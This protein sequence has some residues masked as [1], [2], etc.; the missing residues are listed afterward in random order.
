MDRSSQ[1]V[2]NMT[3]LMLGIAVAQFLPLLVSPILTRLFSPEEFGAF[4][5]FCSMVAFLAVLVSGRYELALVLPR[6][7]NGALSLLLL[8]C[9]LAV[10]NSLGVC[11]L[12]Y[13]FNDEISKFSGLEDVRWL[14]VLPIAMLI[15]GVSQC[16]IQWYTRLGLFSKI[17]YNK[18]VVSFSSAVLGILLG[19]LGLDGG[20]IVAHVSGVFVGVLILVKFSFGSMKRL[21]LVAIK[22]ALF[23]GKKYIKFPLWNLPNGLLDHVRLLGSSVLIIRFFGD[24]ALGQYAIAYKVL[25]APIY[26][27]GGSVASVFLERMANSSRSDIL[28][29]VSWY[30]VRS[31]FLGLPFYAIFYLFSEKLFALTFGE[32]W[33][34]AGMVAKF[35]S[36]WFFMS[37]LTSPLSVVFLVLKKQEVQFVLSCIYTLIPLI[38][39][40]KFSELGFEN[41]LRYLSLT[42]SIF[43]V[44]YLFCVYLIVRARDD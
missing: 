9:L 5:I 18:V 42:M 37:L 11:F 36:P 38:V 33:S 39:I 4:S 20:L 41:T 1:L 26:I 23:E 14:Y 8:S 7:E 32:E 2:Q 3:V 13:V 25:Q 24:S 28:A 27:A 31:V 40:Y 29:L 34:A 30:L 16:M 43:L 21:N 6:E 22:A 10:F 35:L 15:T 12:V 17:S 19:L 44:F